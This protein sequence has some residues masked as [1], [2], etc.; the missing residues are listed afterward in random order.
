[1]SILLV[2]APSGVVV[3]VKWDCLGEVESIMWNKSSLSRFT[4]SYWGRDE[5]LAL[6]EEGQIRRTRPAH[7]FPGSVGRRKVSQKRTAALAAQ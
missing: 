5:E 1:M 7:P 6:R 2:V 4:A 3:R